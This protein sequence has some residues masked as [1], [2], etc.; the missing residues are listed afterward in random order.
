MQGWGGV[1]GP[2][3]KDLFPHPKLESRPLGPEEGEG[4]MVGNYGHTWPQP[5]TGQR[6]EGVELALNT[7]QTFGR[8]KQ[9]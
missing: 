9:D 8:G 5:Y 2:F 3:Q 7:G 1:G 6:T 4:M